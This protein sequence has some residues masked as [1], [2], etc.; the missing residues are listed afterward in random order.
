[1][2]P[3]YRRRPTPSELRSISSTIGRGRNLRALRRLAARCALVSLF[4]LCLSA[5]QL[6]SAQDCETCVEGVPVTVQAVLFSS[7][8]SGS[9]SI[10]LY[11]GG[12]D[13]YLSATN[14]GYCETAGITN[15]AVFRMKPDETYFVLSSRFM[16]GTFI[17][18]DVPQGYQLYAK[19]D[20]IY[21]NGDWEKVSTISRTGGFSGT[22]DGLWQIVLR[23]ECVC[24]EVGGGGTPGEEQGPALGA[25]N[26]AG[27]PSVMW[28]VGLGDLAD[29]RSAESI[30]IRQEN[31][32]AVYS[33]KA[34]IYTSPVTT[35]EIDTVY[36]NNDGTVR[37]SGSSWTTDPSWS[38]P[39]GIVRQVKTPQTFVDVV[40]I[41]DSEYDLRFYPPESVGAKAGGL[42]TLTGQPFVTWKIKNPQPGTTNA[43]SISEIEGGSTESEEIAWDSSI[44]SWV[45]SQGAGL[46]AQ[47]RSSVTSPTDP[48]QRTE[49]VIRKNETGQIS[50]KSLKT[51][52]QFPWGEELIQE[53]A[54]P[55]GAAL[56]TSYQ[57]Y[58]NP[59]EVERY[60]KMQSVSYPDGSW[61]KYDYDPYGNR[62]LIIRPWKDQPLEDASEY[63]SRST[64]YTYTNTDGRTTTPFARFLASATELVG[65]WE[66]GKTTWTRAAATVNGHPAVTVSETVYFS[67]AQ[68]QTT[69]TTEFYSNA[70]ALLAGKLASIEYPDGRL[71]TYSYEAGTYTPNANPALSQF[72][73]DV[74]GNAQR[75]TVTHGTVGS[76]NGLALRTTKEMSVL[77]QFGNTVLQENYVYNGTSYERVAWNVTE[78]NNRGREVLVTGHDGHV[79]SISWDGNR[80]ASEI[81]GAGV[82]VTYTYDAVGRVKT[83]TK[84][85]IAAGGGFAAQPDIVATYTYDADSHITGE[86]HSAGGLSLSTTRAYDKAGRPQ[87]ETD[88]AGLTTAYSYSNGGR[89]KTTTL[90]GGATEIADK[91]VDGSARSLTGTAVVA[92]TFNYDINP[93]GTRYAQVFVGSAGPDS[94]RW[95][96]TTADWMGRT[97]KVE[98]PTI[99]TETVTFP[100]T[101][102][103]N[104]SYYN[105]AGQLQRERK[106]YGIG[107]GKL[108][109]D[110]LYEYDELGN[111]VRSGIDVDAD[112]QLRAVSIDRLTETSAAFEK[113]GSDWFSV[114]TAKSYFKD[115]DATAVS[116]TQK[117]R[118]NNF[119][120][121][122]SVKTVAETLVFD[123]AGNQSKVTTTIDRAAKKMVTT[124]DTP[125]SATDAVTITI[126]GLLQ[127]SSPS[128]PETPTVY[129]YDS[130]ARLTSVTDPRSGTSARTYSPTTGQVV[131][132][133]NGPQTITSEYYPSTHLNAGRLKS[134]SKADGKKVYFAY[135]SRGEVVQTWGDATYPV[136]NVYDAYGQKTEMRTFRAGSGWGASAWPTSTT[137]AA[138]VTRWF[139]HEPT[140]LLTEKQDA[141]SSGAA[142]TYDMMGRVLT[143]QWARTGA[144]GNRIT[145]T[146]AY[147]SKTGSLNVI[148][149]SDGTPQVTFNPDRGGRA[150]EIRDAAGTRALT[151]N[152]AGDPQSEQTTGGILDGVNVAIGYDGFLR[153]QSLQAQRG[154]TVLLNQTYGYD[155]SARMQT[156][157]EGGQ[158]ATYAY[159]PTRGLLNTTTFTGGTQLSRVYD[160]SGRV[161][162]ITTAPAADTP[163]SYAYI[164]NN[165][166]QRTTAT[167]ED[168]SNWAYSY[169]DRGELMSG[170]RRWSDGTSVAGQQFE[171][172][173]DNVGN[174]DSA[175]A[176]GDAAGANLRQLTYA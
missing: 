102:L 93:D 6:V 34:L 69:K 73:A 112:D 104:V 64:R 140:G 113:I 126:N 27:Q 19:V 163:Q 44:Q 171:F 128:T 101:I 107:T 79:S 2:T 94:P 95:S 123:V 155:T 67:A 122:G 114:T 30:S 131:S 39:Y 37:E 130:L 53:V 124:T 74:N 50:S 54:D 71:D 132:T 166:N 91:F 82:E 169:N 159:H 43:M 45:L 99:I 28:A 20:P 24:C 16:C 106:T 66:A 48:D 152:D 138:D 5:A 116:H 57:F 145:T 85:G 167:R 119:P 92:R 134:R 3:Q 146:Y 70:P 147:D 83:R 172:A 165:L 98:T 29:G 60:R 15:K 40:T 10:E 87:S 121:N 96:K 17:N 81:D 72:T 108:Q 86:V 68:G 9:A 142:Y 55:D 26:A 103:I 137:G 144:G 78:Y 41:S 36:V 117:E 109:A 84:K 161:E 153:R 62:D 174:R 76:P 150:R 168:G 164:Y 23:Q 42:Y 105:A 173:F 118:L 51:Y 59:S 97:I 154:A 77:D 21:G 65:G 111:L 38:S 12:H 52:R 157:T 170:K 46:S 158:T 88:S 143:R 148:A 139:Y 133:S 135:S 141:A 18:F 115:N 56:T 90:P 176:G 100:S 160:A 58:E 89:T 8:P 156:V 125:D 31:L 61:E 162:S 175:K 129:A 13:A 32:N 25:V 1:M 4:I 110:I 49:T 120:V 63:S 149:Y 33:P 75:H 80:K 22:G 14:L 35:N 47:T 11:G 136:E 7:S 127:S 151:Y